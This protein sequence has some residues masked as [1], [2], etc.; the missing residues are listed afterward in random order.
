MAKQLAAIR[1]RF[2]EDEKSLESGVLSL[3]S[4]ESVG[5]AGLHVEGRSEPCRVCRGTGIRREQRVPDQA[6]AEIG[7]F[8][9]CEA[10]RERW[11]KCVET[12]ER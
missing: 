7:T 12:L 9:R 4:E 6:I 10:G 8:C 2:A 5:A 3:E 11:G 1:M